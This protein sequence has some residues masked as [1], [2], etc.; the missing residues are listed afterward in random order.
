MDQALAGL[1]AHFDTLYAGSGRSSI[2]PEKLLRGLLL[3]ALYSIR[4]ALPL[5]CWPRPKRCGLGRDGVYQE[6]R[7]PVERRR[8]GASTA[9]RG[10][11][12]ARATVALRRALQH[13]WHADPGLGEPAQL[14]GEAGAARSR[15][16]RARAQA[17]RDTH[18]STTD[19]DARLYKKSGTAAAVPSYLGR[20]LIEKFV[21]R[22]RLKSATDAAACA[23]R[24]LWSRA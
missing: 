20:V 17:A 16:R 8:G 13:R 21:G 10:R 19:K 14:Q 23:K 7:S 11:A 3:Q 12:G 9:G 24:R 2:A 22:L 1:S 18:E 15:H 6:P 5:V 4:P